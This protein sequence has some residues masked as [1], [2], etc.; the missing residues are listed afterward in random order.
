MEWFGGLR[1]WKW[2][3]N[4]WKWVG[5]TC[6]STWK[7]V[8]NLWK[9]VRD[10]C[11]PTWTRKQEYKD[12]KLHL[13][14][15]VYWYFVLLYNFLLSLIHICRAF[16]FDSRV[17]RLN[18]DICNEDWDRDWPR[19]YL[20]SKIVRFIAYPIKKFWIGSAKILFTIIRSVKRTIRTLFHTGNAGLDPDVESGK[21]ENAGEEKP[22]TREEAEEDSVKKAS[23]AYC[24]GL[25]EAF[26][27]DRLEREIML[28]IERWQ[29]VG[30]LD[31]EIGQLERYASQF[32][33]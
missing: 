11:R 29:G 3:G 17:A 8:G 10:T 7:W 32:A 20:L 21:R 18:I 28:Q 19:P 27:E 14:R 9:W 24:A 1:I 16:G 30:I 13:K 12:K 5:D 23:N 26:H 31:S 2:V 33:Q 4:L 15:N 22:P 25:R 6:R